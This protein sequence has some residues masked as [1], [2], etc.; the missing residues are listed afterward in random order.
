MTNTGWVLTY[1]LEASDGASTV[2]RFDRAFAGDA[3]LGSA[4]RE[5]GVDR[6]MAFIEPGAV[7]LTVSV[8][9]GIGDEGDPYD[10]VL[11]AMAG[12]QALHAAGAL[13]GGCRLTSGTYCRDDGGDDILLTFP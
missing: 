5:A 13:S 7:L 3:G 11:A 8:V 6:V 12:I 4:L 9:A 10:A 2:E 1:A